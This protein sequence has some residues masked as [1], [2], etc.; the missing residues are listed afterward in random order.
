MQELFIYKR[1]KSSM[2]EVPYFFSWFVFRLGW[3]CRDFYPL[4]PLLSSYQLK[5]IHRVKASFPGGSMGKGSVCNAADA[6]QVGS[7][8]GLGRSLREGNGNPLQ[9]SCL[10]NPMDFWSSLV[11][12]TAKNLPA[13]RETWVLSLCWEDPLEEGKATTAIFWPGE[14]HELCS[15]WG[16]KESDTTE[17]IA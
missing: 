4:A 17:K 16:C 13:M 9:Y 15:L 1:N 7:I 8:P 14:F 2:I 6:R 3:Q 5:D 11:A 12:Q 10:W